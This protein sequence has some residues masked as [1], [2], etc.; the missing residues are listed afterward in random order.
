MCVGDTTAL[1]HVCQFSYLDEL[2]YLIVTS[3]ADLAMTTTCSMNVLHLYVC[4][5]S[6]IEKIW[7]FLENGVDVNGMTTSGNTPL[8]L[9]VKVGLSEVISL[10]L[11]NK[12]P[13]FWQEP[14]KEIQ[15]SWK[16]Y[17]NMCLQ[18]LRFE[19]LVKC[20]R[21]KHSKQ[22]RWNISPYCSAISTFQCSGSCYAWQ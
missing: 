8:L 2:F 17:V 7:F 13:V 6:A 4:T 10:L 14:I 16:F 18:Q 3:G 19:V 15:L 1:F 9:T 22:D 11:Q 12:M 5:R 21:C 20:C